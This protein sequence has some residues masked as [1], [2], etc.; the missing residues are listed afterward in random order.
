VIDPLTRNL[1]GKNRDSDIEQRGLKKH[2]NMLPA[3]TSQRNN[4]SLCDLGAKLVGNRMARSLAVSA[5]NSLRYTPSGSR[6]K[7]QGSQPVSGWQAS[8]EAAE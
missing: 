2:L 3:Y 5:M 1:A 7:A 8:E 6:L 4:L